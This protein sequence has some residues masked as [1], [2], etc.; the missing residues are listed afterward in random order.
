MEM[1]GNIL[2]ALV[3]ILLILVAIAWWGVRTPVKRF[4]G[5]E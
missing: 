1:T 5:P 3:M 4:K 2:W